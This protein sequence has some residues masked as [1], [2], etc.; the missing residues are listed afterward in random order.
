M[1]RATELGGRLF[2]NNVGVAWTGRVSKLKDGSIL[3]ETPRAIRYGLCVGSSD[4]IG[5]MP[6]VITQE[7]VG[8]QVAMFTACEAKIGGLKLTTEQKDFL[9]SVDAH[10]GNAILATKEIDLQ[11][12]IFWKID[13]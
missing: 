6:V 7:M 12:K 1:I 9:Y 3:I 8:L 2:R 13:L 4:L 5:W 10:G 11:H